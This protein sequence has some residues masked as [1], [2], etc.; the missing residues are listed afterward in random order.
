MTPIMTKSKKV[1]FVE[2]KLLKESLFDLN[3]NIFHNVSLY[4]DM[5]FDYAQKCSM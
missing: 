5:K 4:Y 1:L 2:K 3:F